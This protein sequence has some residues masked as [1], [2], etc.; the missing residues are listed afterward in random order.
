MRQQGVK[1]LLAFLEP[2]D[3]KEN[4]RK[5]TMSENNKPYRQCSSVFCRK[6]DCDRCY[7]QRMKELASSPLESVVQ[8]RLESPVPLSLAVQGTPDILAELRA[9]A[10]K[11][12]ANAKEMIPLHRTV[13]NSLGLELEF[14]VIWACEWFMQ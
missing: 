8:G 14:K 9:R 12:I 3:S 4:N 5:M 10:V 2:Q 1:V 13:G 7:D 6:G 11:N